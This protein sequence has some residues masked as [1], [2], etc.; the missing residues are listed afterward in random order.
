MRSRLIALVAVVA[1]AACST[2]SNAPADTGMA[3]QGVV[4][5][6][7]DRAAEEAAIK[8][9]DEQFFK[10]MNAKD[11]AAAA[12]VYSNDAVV[13]PPNSPLL[14]GNAAVREYLDAFAKT[15]QLAITGEATSVNFSDDGTV[16]Y[17]TGKYSSTFADDK[18]KTIK[19]D[20]KYL[21]VLKKVDGKWKVVAEAFN[22]DMAPGQ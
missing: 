14:V 20:G 15:P 22:S 8:Q 4:T 11:A 6:P 1:V 12:A 21:L 13:M 3:A 2:K 17:E 7:A 5:P 9:A 10:A 19:D 18:G 16:A